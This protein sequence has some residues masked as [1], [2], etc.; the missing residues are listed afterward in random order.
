MTRRGLARAGGAGLLAVGGW[1]SLASAAVPK[2][3]PRPDDDGF[4]LLLVAA[5]KV[6][7]DLYGGAS[8]VLFSAGERRRLAGLER[9][10]RTAIRYATAALASDAPQ[11][12]DLAS[13]LPAVD[14]RD[15]AR[16]LGL[17]ERLE[18]LTCG[19]GVAAV[20]ATE[21]PNT[22]LLLA[23]LLAADAQ[24]L[25]AVRTLAGLPA[26]TGLLTPVALDDAG[27]VLDRYLVAP[28]A[29]SERVPA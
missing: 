28:T 21:D 24:A 22:R 18:R 20:P 4:L 26:N 2:A 3:T 27:T 6:L 7:S 5:A 12:G 16:Y 25:A 1:S 17:A 29:P 11:P 14:I 19:V 10:K 13:S 8:P 15:R 23:R 9:T